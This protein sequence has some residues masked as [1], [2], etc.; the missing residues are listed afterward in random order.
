MSAHDCTKS[1]RQIL[2]LLQ[3]YKSNEAAH[4][5]L[6]KKQMSTLFPR[7][8]LLVESINNC[9]GRAMLTVGRWERKL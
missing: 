8:Q 3:I 6:V 9:P 5:D 2:Y 4:I 1:K 7:L